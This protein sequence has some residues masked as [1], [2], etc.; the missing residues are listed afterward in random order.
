[1]VIDVDDD[2]DHDQPSSIQDFPI[3][4][5]NDPLLDSYHSSS[6]SGN[7]IPLPNYFDGIKQSMLSVS[8]P[9]I[10]PSSASSGL[11]HFSEVSELH[12]PYHNSS[13]S[14]DKRRQSTSFLSSISRD[15]SKLNSWHAS[16]NE[17]INFQ[18]NTDDNSQL[19]IE[20]ELSYTTGTI[21]DA[22]SSNGMQPQSKS[23]SNSSNSS[24]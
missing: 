9:S 2:N 7:S 8:D 17:R 18:L 4:P 16:H 10:R 23:N 14:D 24:D 13:S 6:S 21:L 1:M 20:N 11:S 22:M 15:D 19:I 12:S 5:S 3:S